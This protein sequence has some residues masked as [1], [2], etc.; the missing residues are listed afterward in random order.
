MAFSQQQIA[1]FE[2]IVRARRS[3]RGFLPDAI[4]QATLDKVFNLAQT[5][6]SNCNIQPWQVHVVSGKAAAN[7]KQR[8]TEHMLKG[9]MQMDFPFIP[10]YQGEHKVRQ[11]D[12]AAQLY[13]AMGVERQDMQGRHEAFLRNFQFFDAPYAA[14]IFI[15]EELG[16][17]EASDAGMYAQNLMLALTAYGLG[18]CAQAAQSFHANCVREVLQLPSSLKLLYG[19]A[20]GYE[21][22][23]VLANNTRVGREPLDQ[24]VTFH[25]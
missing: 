19:I 16:T 3:V 8:L 15:P 4:E 14:M 9:E 20:F 17:R 1:H 11:Y 12:A 5:A 25:H 24:A 18:S 22:T 23:S 6:P 10:K 7:I 2:E 13:G 21:D